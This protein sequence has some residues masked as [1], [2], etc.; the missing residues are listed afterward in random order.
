M[1][2]NPNDQLVLSGQQ[3]S[4]S[5]NSTGL[6]VIGNETFS[7][8]PIWTGSPVGTFALQTSDDTTAGSAQPSASSWTTIA[9]SVTS[10][11]GLNTMI[12]AWTRTKVP[13]NWVR[14]TY[15]FGSGTGLLTTL[16]FNGH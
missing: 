8:Q 4:G 6:I 15:N 10:T 14:V 16:R 11:V 5:F 3:M 2:V 13:F 9:A 12:L 1:A 7:F